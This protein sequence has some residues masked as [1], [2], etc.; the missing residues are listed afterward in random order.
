MLGLLIGGALYCAFGSFIG[1]LVHGFTNGGDK[2]TLRSVAIASACGLL[3]PVT[4]V[5]ALYIL[6]TADWSH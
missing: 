6:F 4:C 3:W 5:V 2:P 1:F